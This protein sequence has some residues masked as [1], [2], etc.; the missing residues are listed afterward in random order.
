MIG[1]VFY[2]GAVGELSPDPERPSV[3]TH[4]Q[5]LVR[6]DMIRPDA[7]DLPGEDAFRFMHVLVHD[8]AY[9]AIGKEARADLHRRVAGWLEVRAGGRLPEFDEI[10][11]Y[12]V[13]RPHERCW[14][15]VS[16]MTQQER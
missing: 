6:R 11:G 9:R 13:N 4:L 16:L 5:A 8:A 1:K 3:G 7:S 12:H 2:W 15:L 14:T 10:I